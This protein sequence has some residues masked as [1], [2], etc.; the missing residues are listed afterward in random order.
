MMATILAAGTTASA[1]QNALISRPD[2]K[3]EDGKFTPELIEAFGRASDPQL[4]PDKKKILYN[5]EFINLEAD[6]GNKELWVMDIDGKNAVQLT[7][8]NDPEVNAV[9]FNEGKQI[10]FLSKAENGMQ[11]FVMDADGKNRKQISNVEKGLSGFS[12]SP[13]EKK[14]LFISNVQY[15]KTTQEI[16]PKLDKATY[17]SLTI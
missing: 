16:Y 5:L 3:V 11:L 7:F 8:T 9:W 17:T 13:D 12:F 10:A 4:S 2:F 15:G 14:V 6:K 1:E